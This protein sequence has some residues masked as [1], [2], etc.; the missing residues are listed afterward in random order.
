MSDLI[1]FRIHS[2]GCKVNTYDSGLLQ[3]RM[4]R[5]GFVE[6]DEQPQVHILNTC[7]VTREAT[8]EAVKL[9]RRL[10]AKNPLS[11]V[12]VTGCA[13]QVDTG[14][15]THVP[16]VD[17]VVAN[18][19]KG[20][21]ENLIRKYYS[22]ELRERVHKSNIFKKE[23]LEP[24][25]G[26]ETGHTRSFLKIQDGCNSFCTFC[27][28]PFARGKSR[29]LTIA[30]ITRRVQQ[31]TEAGVKE[32]VFTGVHIG[33]YDDAGRGLEDLIGAVLHDTKVGRLRL[34]SLEPVEVTPRLLELYA[35]ERLCRH[36]HMS[37]QSAST[38]VLRDMKRKYASEDVESALRA[39]ER[40][41]PGAF[42]GMDVIAGFPGESDEEFIDST[43]RLR[44]LPWTKLHVF[45][46]SS[47]PGTFAARREDHVSAEQIKRRA[48]ILRSLS[49]ERFSR[50]AEAQVG[51]I[52]RALVLRNGRLLSRD[53]WNVELDGVGET[54][55]N[56]ELS[57]R[58]SSVVSDGLCATL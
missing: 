43:D 41:V 24:G 10:K 42:V 55:I 1:S 50:S 3:S 37:I 27:V 5:S 49:A 11:L 2:F 44:S 32:I 34:S 29:S 54:M 28:I 46:Y 22:G 35:D 6:R 12:V 52:K 21:L 57:V 17:L 31:L 36:F 13:A 25:G 18:S 14:E 16:G 4:G 26:I 7:A 23:D 51:S 45:P 33:D 53:F 40:Q 8:R 15:F 19:H 9:A 39:I 20:D 58:I 30:D 38:K 47:R 48:E 56:Q